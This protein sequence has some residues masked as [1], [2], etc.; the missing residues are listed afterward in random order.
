MLDVCQGLAKRGHK[1]SMLYVKEGN[2]LK[3]YRKFCHKM[4]EV[5]GYRIERKERIK[6]LVNF[7]SDIT[8][9]PASDYSC[10]YSNQYQ[11]NFWGA[12]L[13]LSR[14]I[15]LICHLRLPPP[16]IKLGWQWSMG[17]KGVKQFI[18][19][20]NQTKQDWVNRGLRSEKIEVVYNGLNPEMFKQ[21]ESFSLARQAWGIA[22]NVKVISYVGRLDRE[23][24]VE[25]L[26]KAFAIIHQDND[27]SRLI[28]AG[29]PLST[30]ADYKK[31]LE[32][33]SEDL[34]L[35]K[36]VDF[37]G[38]VNNPGSLYQM[39]DLTV[40]P[41]INSEPFGRVIIESMACGTPVV[42][43]RTGGIPEILTGEFQKG[44]F[45][46]GNSIDLSDKIKLLINWRDDSITLGDR[47]REYV[48]ERF[49][50][51]KTIEGVEKAILK[52]ISNK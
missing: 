46:P 41:S 20:S 8:K 45:Q 49:G 25:T 23:K 2:L 10:V 43:S 18:T 40:L 33:L 52:A 42:A 21:S 4:I 7:L 34:G 24:G 48:I 3:H 37:L 13:A 16:D 47:C 36:Y 15:P 30:K 26:I 17:L 27:S 39:S 11:D 14:N 50:L 19:I 12:A 38:H 44:L 28:I 31:S 29:K 32:K 5:N 51:E 9:I 1:I 35:E 22:E 6:S